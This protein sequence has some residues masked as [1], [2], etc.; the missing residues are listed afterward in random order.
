ME[1]RE[2]SAPLPRD[3]AA[4]IEVGTLTKRFG[5]VLA[6]D[7]VSF[8]VRVGE[9][10]GF[11]GPNG[12]GKTTTINMLTGLARPD[13]GT[14]RIAG[15]DCA[16]EPKAAQHLVGVVPDESNLYPELSGFDNL[17]FCAAL[18]GMRKGERQARARRLLETFGLTAAADRKFEAYSKGMKRKLTMAAGIIH[19]PQVLFLDEP[20]TGV[21]VASA[22]H[23]RQLIVELHRAGTTIVLTTHY[24][25]EA[26]R[27]CERIVFLV[28]GRIVRIDTVPNLL[29]PVREKHVLEVS[30]AAAGSI[31]YASLAGAFPGVEFQAVSD[32]ALRVESTLP[33]RVGPLVRFLEDHGAE[34]TEARRVHPS[35]EEVFLRITGI[36]ADAMRKEKERGAVG[37]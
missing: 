25:E 31:P 36:E 27:L 10:L 29:E 16:A 28:A 14:I 33:I 5:E 2:P 19:A 32:M 13:S 4:C 12:A 11:L 15:F 37:A 34:V 18:Y 7:G 22:R 26:E 21:D 8:D 20:T 1:V 6:V 9:L 30:L 3:A 35:L 24:I 23:I 17:C